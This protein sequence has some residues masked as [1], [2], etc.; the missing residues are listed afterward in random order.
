MF[1]TLLLF[2]SL[3]TFCTLDEH[4]YPLFQAAALGRLFESPCYQ[5]IVHF[6]SFRIG[7]EGQMTSPCL[8]HPTFWTRKMA[9]PEQQ[10]PGL[11]HEL[12]VP[13]QPPEPGSVRPCD[14]AMT[15]L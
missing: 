6:S 4:I 12:G 11:P 1:V 8:G 9:Y 2:Y 7:E 15:V 14:G 5:L 3:T 10:L 13:Q